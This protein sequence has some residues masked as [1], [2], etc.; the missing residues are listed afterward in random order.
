MSLVGQ[1][2]MYED[3][4]ARQELASRIVDVDFDKQRTRSEINGVGVANESAAEGL[5][6]EFIEGQGSGRIGPRSTG[7]HLRNRDVQAE[8]ANGGDVKELS[9][10]WIVPGIDECSDVRIAGRDYAGERSI[11]LFERLQLFQA[12]HVGRTGFDRGFHCVEIAGR[13]VG[14][15][16]RHGARVHQVL[17]AARGNLGDVQVGLRGIQVSASL[18]QLLV[19]FWG[20]DLRKQLA[21]LNE[22]TNVALP[23]LEIS[24]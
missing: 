7:V 23:M 15:L 16:L 2:E 3:V 20:F 12:P 11:D 4:R 17:P 5:A 18:Q 1:L 22:R 24:T 9:R 21:F 13:L 8:R 6:R 10:L 19:E 14:F